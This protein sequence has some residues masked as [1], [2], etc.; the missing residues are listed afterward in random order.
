MRRIT[1]GVL[2]VVVAGALAFS[3]AASVADPAAV[4][5]AYAHG[6]HGSHHGG[7]S[8]TYYTCGGHSAHLHPDG[9]CPYASDSTGYYCGVSAKTLKKVQKLLC[10]QGYDCGRKD[11]VMCADTK[12]AIK[13]F[14]RANGLTADGIIGPKTLS[15]LGL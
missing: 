10:R 2:S 11:G 3:P 5:V 6:H 15:A 4:T 8:G 13:K 9:V 7:C 12:R 14:Q 1:R